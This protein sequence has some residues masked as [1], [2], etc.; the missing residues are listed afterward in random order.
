MTSGFTVNNNKINIGFIGCGY[1]GPNLIR[2]MGQLPGTRVKAVCDSDPGKEKFI[3][4]N[5]SGVE[6]LIDSN[7]LLKDDSIDAI[8]IVS[9]AKTHYKLAKA[10]LEAGK[11]I[12]VE[13]PLALS[14]AECRE[15]IGLAKEKKKVLMVGHT[16]EYNA[17][18]NKVKEYIDSGELGE[19]YYIY[20]QRLN[21]GRLRNDINAMWNFAPHDISIILYWLGIEPVRVSARGF[22]YLQPGIEDVAFMVLEFAQR[23]SA[24]IHISWLDPHKTRMMT[25]VGS[26]KMIVYDDVSTDAKIKI[27]DKGFT[28]NNELGSFGNFDSFAKFQLIQRAGGLEIPRFEFKEPLQVE[29]SHFLDCILN[30]K[31]PLTDGESALRVVRV[32]EAA[33]KSMENNGEAIKL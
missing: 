10:C 6:F 14:S 23:I 21:L 8:V 32:L 30:N 5:Y 3:K 15:L 1:W 7:R 11:H 24:H 13:K 19:I 29:C 20:S 18:V 12:L 22:S 9:P 4:E 17:A 27:Y 25:I 2:N 28:K 31:K 16:F 33:Q 26:K